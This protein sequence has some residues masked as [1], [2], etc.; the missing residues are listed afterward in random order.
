MADRGEKPQQLHYYH[1]FSDSMDTYL[2]KITMRIIHPR[3]Y[4]PTPLAHG[5]QPINSHSHTH[6]SPTVSHNKNSTFSH[7]NATL[8]PHTMGKNI[9][10]HHWPRHSDT[11]MAPLSYITGMN[12]NNQWLPTFSTTKCSNILNHQW[13]QHSHMPMF[14]TIINPKHSQM[15]MTQAFT[16]TNGLKAPTALTTQMSTHYAN[17][18]RHLNMLAYML[19]FEYV[20]IFFWKCVDIH[21]G[22]FLTSSR[23]CRHLNVL[24]YMPASWS[25]G[26]WI[27]QH[28]CQ[29][30]K[31][32]VD[33]A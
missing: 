20:G 3:W 10:S 21:V 26:I 18:C 6:M 29:H 19:A 13:S 8:I 14:S 23:M 7:P 33:H 30:S 32:C 12:I 1:P 31:K 9:L 15:Q 24:A 17:I 2:T 11:P 25:V 4:R 16:I 27:C 28:F 5:L 22:I